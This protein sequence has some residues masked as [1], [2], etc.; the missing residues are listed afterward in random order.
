MAIKTLRKYAP[1]SPWQLLPN[2]SFGIAFRK[3]LVGQQNYGVAF[4]INNNRGGDLSQRFV[5]YVQDDLTGIARL[6]I[7]IFGHVGGYEEP[8]DS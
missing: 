5:G 8:Y 2:G 7:K 1:R 3:R 6:R 4:R